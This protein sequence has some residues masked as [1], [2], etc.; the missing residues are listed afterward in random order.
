MSVDNDIL[1]GKWI[2]SKNGFSMYTRISRNPPSYPAPAIVL[3][4][5]LAVSSR[6]MLPTAVRLASSYAVYV[7]D[8]P[9]FGRSEKPAHILSVR[10]LAE[11]L[12]A[13]MQ[14]VGL[15]SATFLGNSLGCQVIVNA[16]LRYPKR[17]QRTIL[18]GP[19][20]DPQARTI[21]RAGVRLLCDGFCEPMHFLPVLVG[22][23]SKAGMR[24]T[25]GTL[26]YAFADRIEQH[27]PHVH[28]PTLVV[29]GSR[30]PIVSQQWVEQVNRLLPNSQL[31]VVQ[32]AGH[33]VN[34][35]SP[36]QLAQITRQF[37]SDLSY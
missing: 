18:V 8:L 32:G 7:P 14:A 16:A 24:R 12:I 19:T 4:H 20:M 22:E 37:L 3:V 23:Y 29:R 11:T 2:T 36:E 35:N 30:D 21:Q 34:Y 6:Y 1:E 25:L 33:A 27:L 17:I 9:G 31:A 15:S 28:A 26:R 5:G 10:E 13:W